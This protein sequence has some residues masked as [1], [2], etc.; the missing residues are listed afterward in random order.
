M[1]VL[2]VSC[3]TGIGK[4]N[5]RKEFDWDVSV[6]QGIMLV[7]K[8]IAGQSHLKKP[9]TTTCVERTIPSKFNLGSS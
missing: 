9:L 1:E 7:Q 2:Q 6:S 5:H 8:K 4:E 3:L